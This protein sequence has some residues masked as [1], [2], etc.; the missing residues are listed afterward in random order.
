MKGRLFFVSL[1]LLTILA[2]CVENP[3]VQ[4]KRLY[5]LHCANCHLDQGQGLASMNP[6]L[7]DVVFQEDYADHFG[8][9]VRFGLNDTL[10]IGIRTYDIPMPGN[11]DLTAAEIA[12]IYNYIV[13]SW[14]PEMAKTT[15]SEIQEQLKTCTI[16]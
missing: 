15:E 12:N 1:I 16:K 14:H 11:K 7:N 9:I 10:L 4:G 5:D 3:Y 8:C 6:P 2:A 13:H